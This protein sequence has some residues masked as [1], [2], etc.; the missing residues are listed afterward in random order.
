ML[1]VLFI[2]ILVCLI[3]FKGKAVDFSDFITK[4][5]NKTFDSRQTLLVNNKTKKPNKVVIHCLY[6]ILNIL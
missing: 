5:E 3:I 2:L 6:V 1:S 4:T